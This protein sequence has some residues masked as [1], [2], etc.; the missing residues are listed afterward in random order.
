MRRNRNGTALAI[1]I[2]GLAGGAS[3]AENLEFVVEHLPEVAM[4]NRYASLPLWNSCGDGDRTCFG[5]NAAWSRTQSG[6]LTLEGPMLGLSAAWP[7]GADY[8]LNG[9]AFLDSFALSSG[10]ERRPL[11]VLFANPP[12]TMPSDAEFSGLDGSARDVGLGLALNGSAHPRW[13]PAFDWSAGLLWQQFELSDYRFDYLVTGGPDSG[14]TGTVDY[15][16]TYS[17]ITPFVGAA[18]RRTHGAWHYAPH[19]QLAVP[20]PRHGIQGRITGPGFDLSGNTEDNGN[21]KH[22]GDPSVTIGFNVTYE[23]WNLTLDVGGSITQALLEPYIH[24]GVEQNLVL[25][26]Y[27]DF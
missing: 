10:V 22:F 14:T 3:G 16:A 13:L 9:F 6:T 26:A 21:G 4:D 18:W 17:H 5:V 25:S 2:A 1:L 27:W 12:L 19:V 15:S 11:E 7:L 20:L 23:P 24:K 8:Q